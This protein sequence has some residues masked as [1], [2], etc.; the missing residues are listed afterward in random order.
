LQV[1]IARSRGAA[2]A[3]W[4]GLFPVAAALGGGLLRWVTA[5]AANRG[6]VI[7]CLAL[8]GI[9][10]IV[11]ALL[12]PDVKGVGETTETTTIT[13]KSSTSAEA[14]TTRVQTAAEQV[15][16]A[17]KRVSEAGSRQ[18]SGANEAAR[19]LE[20]STE[21]LLTLQTAIESALEQARTVDNV[22]ERAL[23]VLTGEQSTI[24][25]AALSMSE[26]RS[27]VAAIANTIATLAG[28]TQR[29]DAIITTVSEIAT[30]SNLLALNASIEAARAGVH[31][32][33]FAV[34]ADEVRS[35]AG[36]ST[37]AAKQVRA[38]L[39]DIQTAMRDTVRATEVGIEGADAGVTMT[40]H[41]N[42]ILDQ[43]AGNVA[44]AYEAVRQFQSVL[45]A[46]TDALDTVIGGLDRVN[47]IAQDTL[48]ETR[49]VE[50]VS[51]NLS[52]LAS[53]LRAGVGRGT[54]S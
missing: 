44:R 50:S 37:A 42:T 39:V 1:V 35:L 45:R 21:Q 33:G 25:S 5:D 18:S 8:L 46:Q 52:Y 26:I 2:R 9:G 47:R 49:S 27:Q 23:D 16:K 15:E 11:V 40:Q 28:L 6:E 10:Q 17:A 7:L 38:I 34:V 43:V 53:E 12:L 22:A 32:R 19:V 14:L 30:Q 41:M 20:Y 31:G 36:Q 51:S 3:L 24:R 54:S 4:Y 29:I 48:T 13:F